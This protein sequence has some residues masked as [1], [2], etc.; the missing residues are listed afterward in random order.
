MRPL[1]GLTTSEIRHP[2]P[3]ELIPHADAGR[4]DWMVAREGDKLV[5][6]FGAPKGTGPQL[7]ADVMKNWKI[8]R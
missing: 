2:D 4:E 3:G 5:L 6:I 1:I 8:S 7:V